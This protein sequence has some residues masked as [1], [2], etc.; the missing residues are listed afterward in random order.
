MQRRVFLG[1]LAAG[2]LAAGRTTAAQGSKDR[3]RL[4]PIGLQWANLRLP[5]IDVQPLGP[6]WQRRKL[7]DN[8]TGYRRCR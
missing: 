1:S 3:V 4:S 7:Q 2:A 8:D 5:P 6:Y